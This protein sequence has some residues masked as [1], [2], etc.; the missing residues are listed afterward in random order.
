MQ[1]DDEDGKANAKDDMHFDVGYGQDIDDGET[2]DGG[3]D[4]GHWADFNDDGYVD[5][6]GGGGGA[7]NDYD[8]ADY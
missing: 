4:N 2:F 6:G 3:Y 8:D 1:T 7:Y 5:D